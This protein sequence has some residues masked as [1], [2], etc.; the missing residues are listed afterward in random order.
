M[1]RDGLKS[2]QLDK[3]GGQQV[4]AGVLLHMVNAPS[5]INLAVDRPAGTAALG[6]MDHLVGSGGVP[7]RTSTTATPP[8]VPRSCGC[9]PEVG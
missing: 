6:V 1:K 4:L 3:R 7:S 8:S 5:P 9:P 2:K